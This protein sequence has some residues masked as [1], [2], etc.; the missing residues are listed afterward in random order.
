MTAKKKAAADNSTTVQ[1][2]VFQGVV[3]DAK[4]VAT[5]QTV[6]DGFLET[7]KGLSKLVDVFKAQNIT[8]DAMLKIN[9]KEKS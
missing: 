6:A 1:N 8:I 9:S 4:A 3:W 5:I 2:C 7:S